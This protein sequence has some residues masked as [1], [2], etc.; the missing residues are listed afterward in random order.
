VKPVDGKTGC[1]ENG[2]DI[3]AMASFYIPI[4][5]LM[6]KCDSIMPTVFNLRVLQKRDLHEPPALQEVEGKMKIWTKDDRLHMQSGDKYV[7]APIDAVYDTLGADFAERIAQKLRNQSG[8]F[9]LMRKAVA[10]WLQEGG[11]K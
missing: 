2:A 7:S 3:A 4:P 1:I 10:D 5:K 8:Q 6:S 11:W 9:T